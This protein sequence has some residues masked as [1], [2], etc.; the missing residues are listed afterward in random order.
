MYIA[1]GRNKEVI[2]FGLSE[3]QNVLQMRPAK[4]KAWPGL[5]FA[6]TTI[7]GLYWLPDLAPW[8]DPRLSGA[9]KGGAR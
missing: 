1:P 2:F 4:R 8:P 7:V 9:R 6:R 3:L 5:L